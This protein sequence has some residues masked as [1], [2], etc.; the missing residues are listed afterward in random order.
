MRR[1]NL[2]AMRLVG[3]EGLWLRSVK[4]ISGRFGSG[5]ELDVLDRV[6][7]VKRPQKMLD[8]GS[9]IVLLHYFSDVPNF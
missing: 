2:V 3:R 5:R 7:M 8:G 9:D 4:E 1:Q 6:I